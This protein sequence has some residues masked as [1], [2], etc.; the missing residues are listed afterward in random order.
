MQVGQ[1]YANDANSDSAALRP[2]EPAGRTLRHR[3]ILRHS[4][5]DNV[6][7]RRYRFGDRQ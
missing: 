4:R 7:D 2:A 6:T 3:P 5:V 1:V